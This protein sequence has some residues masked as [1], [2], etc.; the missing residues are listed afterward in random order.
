MPFWSATRFDTTR[1]TRNA[2]ASSRPLCGVC[3][4]YG[5]GSP[6]TDP[7]EH[8][9][10]LPV[11][12]VHQLQSTRQFGRS[13]SLVGP[14]CP[15][16]PV[17]PVCEPDPENLCDWQAEL[18]KSRRSKAVS[19]WASKTL[20]QTGNI[21]MNSGN[22]R[23]PAG[24]LAIAALL[25]LVGC[26]KFGSKEST[27]NPNAQQLAHCRQV[28]YLST[29]LVLEAKGYKFD[30]SGIDAAMWFKFTTDSTDPAGLFQTNV[31]DTSGFSTGFALSPSDD[32][33]WW[34]VKGLDLMG[35]QVE[36]PGVKFMN[37]GLLSSDSNTVVYIFW[38]EI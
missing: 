12:S 31:V 34:D 13:N 28:L 38:H 33:P 30:A 27:T 23:Y 26:L 17:G 15:P 11:D 1:I 7:D 2:R 14:A 3:P 19:H 22:H 24:L 10:P 6:R 16:G 8:P 4:I 29:N 37:V 5:S 9:Q 35:G 20:M 18:S 25:S 21:G 32:I 36:L